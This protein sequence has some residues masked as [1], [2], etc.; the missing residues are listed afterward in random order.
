V[1]VASAGVGRVELTA[2]LAPNIDHRDPLFGGSAAAIAS[3]G[4]GDSLPQGLSDSAA[5]TAP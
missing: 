1:R 4:H 3:L 2:P 5:V